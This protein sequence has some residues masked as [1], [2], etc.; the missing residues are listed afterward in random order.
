MC[1]VLGTLGRWRNDSSLPFTVEFA[2][3]L[4][5]FEGFCSGFCSE[6]CSPSGPA[7]SA[8]TSA[9][10]LGSVWPLLIPFEPS[11]G[12]E[13]FEEESRLWWQR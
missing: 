8:A 1:W 11:A 13:G 6:F 12:F 2:L 3:R 5:A 9:G 7:A 10:V 4:L